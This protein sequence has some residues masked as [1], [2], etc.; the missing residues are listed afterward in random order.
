MRVNIFAGVSRKEM[1]TLEIG[2]NS[3]MELLVNEEYAK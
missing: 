3:F 2:L 1:G